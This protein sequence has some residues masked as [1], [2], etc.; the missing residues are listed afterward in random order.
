MDTQQLT[1]GLKQALFI[2]DHRIVFWY[3]ADQ[4]FTEELLRLDVSYP[5]INHQHEAF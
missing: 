5:A 2:E 4:R 3:D 1:H